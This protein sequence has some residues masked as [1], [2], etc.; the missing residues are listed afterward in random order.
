MGILNT[1]KLF[2]NLDNYPN[3][4]EIFHK[5]FSYIYDTSHSRF[6]LNLWGVYIT[7]PKIILSVFFYRKLM[8]MVFLIVYF[9]YMMSKFGYLYLD[10]LNYAEDL[11]KEHWETMT[12]HIINLQEMYTILPEHAKHLRP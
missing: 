1:Y 7:L 10:Y 12:T 3:M 8:I 5:G 9:V 4:Y 11:A 6:R 2:F